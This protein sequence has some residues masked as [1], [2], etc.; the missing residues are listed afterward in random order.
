MAVEAPPPLIAG[1]PIPLVA[2]RGIVKRYGSADGSLGAAGSTAVYALRGIDLRIDRGEFVA[3][4]GPSGSG[5]STLMNILGC[6]DVADR[7]VY[8]LAG[9]DVSQ[10]G[11]DALASVRNRFVG[12]IFQQWNLLARTSAVDNVAL[13]LAY[14]GDRDR[15]RKALVALKAVGLAERGTHRPNQLSGGE[16]QRVAI[17]RA[18]VTQPA[19]LLADEPTG[20]LDS[21]TGAG[22]M[23]LFS[24]LHESGRTVIVVT[25]DSHVADLAQRQVHLLDGQIVLDAPTE[26]IRSGRVTAS[27]PAARS[28]PAMSRVAGA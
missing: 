14:R 8:V 10:L 24:R 6:L 2:M 3:I 28:L 26:A 11:D 25:H 9:V 15:R 19:I 4:V 21:A 20:S 1:R 17:A 7:G 18:L 12:F 13:P 16:Q 22:I 23:R 27:I 5:K